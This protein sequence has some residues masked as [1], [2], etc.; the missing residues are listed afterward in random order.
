MLQNSFPEAY[1][2]EETSQQMSNRDN[3]L[4][5]IKPPE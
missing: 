4:T 1:R 3:S 2:A 5:L